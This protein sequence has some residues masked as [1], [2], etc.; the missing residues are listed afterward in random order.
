MDTPTWIEA[1]SKATKRVDSHQLFVCVPNLLDIFVELEK[2]GLSFTFVVG[3]VLVG[4]YIDTCCCHSNDIWQ[5][6]GLQGVMEDRFARDLVKILQSVD[7][8][9]QINL[10][11]EYDFWQFI[12]EMSHVHPEA[13]YP[14]LS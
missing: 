5:F 6:L 1:I 8:C 2:S 12:E 10:I 9:D 7:K 13:N 3:F 14:K 11:K 4:D